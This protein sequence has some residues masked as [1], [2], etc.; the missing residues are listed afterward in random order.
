MSNNMEELLN[1][2]SRKKQTN[3][4]T[5]S[6]SIDELRE[7]VVKYAQETLG[8]KPRPKYVWGAT[9]PNY[10]DCSGFS[11]DMYKKAGLQIP[12]VSADQGNY[13]D[14]NLKKED[15]KPGDL[16]FFGKNKITHVG[17]YI[18]NGKII[19]SGG[20]GSKNTSSK[21]AGEGVRVK[22]LNYRSDFRGG[23]SLEKVAEKN[24][25]PIK[26]TG[27]IK[28]VEDSSEKTICTAPQDVA[29]DEKR[30][31]KVLDYIFK[32]EGGHSD[33]KNDKGGATKYGIIE[34]EARRH[35]YTGNMKDFPK[36]KA[37][38]IYKKDYYYKNNIDKIA[39]DRVA[40]SVF[41]WGVNS[42]R[43][44]KKIQETLNQKFNFNLAV[45]GIIGEKTLAAM[46][47]VEPDLLLKEIHTA[48][49][50]YYNYL[51]DRDP[52]QKVFLKG[53]MNR[54]D[55]KE[56]FIKKNL[57]PTNKG[58]TKNIS[59]IKEDLLSKIKEITKENKTTDK[60]INNQR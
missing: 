50:G 2:N 12:R 54:V 26:N 57:E 24:K 40:L 17:I 11:R 34:S 18:G 30:L 4:S 42:G 51:A 36:D 59:E 19:D 6:K 25:I 33:H 55:R 60:T 13:V 32:V 31:E 20:G 10:Y 9:G 29:K 16:V 52:S 53:W 46:N 45:D 3:E 1:L 37:I 23:V 8:R 28:K 47:S 44:I 58:M 22:P 35:G 56:D 41:D 39:D 14:R 38:E 15:L 27:N 21:N 7:D 48:Q 43:G 5:N 49:R